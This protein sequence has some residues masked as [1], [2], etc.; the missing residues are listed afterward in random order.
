MKGYS[1]LSD[2][3]KYHIE[4]SSF[5]CMCEWGGFCSHLVYSKVRLRNRMHSCTI[6]RS[7][8]FNLC[9]IITKSHWQH[10][11]PWLLFSIFHYHP[12]LHVSPVSYILRPHRADIRFCCW[13]TLARPCIGV[14][15]RTLLMSSSLLLLQCPPC[16]FTQIV[17]EMGSEWPYSCCFVGR[18]A[19]RIC[20]REFVIFLCS[21]RQVF[22]SIHFV[23]VHIVHSY[24]STDTATAWKKSRFIWTERLGF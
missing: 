11:F 20:L 19:S 16:R 9:I 5:R 21:S 6:I 1:A 8:A 23:S 15:K 22:F 14:H 2:I 18:V 17:F 7:N 13:P 3:I 4:D 10:R 24:S 12:S